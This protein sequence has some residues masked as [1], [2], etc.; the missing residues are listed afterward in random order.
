[1]T[2]ALRGDHNHVCIEEVDQMIDCDVLFCFVIYFFWSWRPVTVVHLFVHIKSDRGSC[3]KNKKRKLERELKTL[4]ISDLHTA[5]QLLCEV[6]NIVRGSVSESYRICRTQPTWFLCWKDEGE[7][8]LCT[9]RRCD[10]HFVWSIHYCL[11]SHPNINTSH[12]GGN[13]TFFMATWRL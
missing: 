11:T 10:K 12:K 7:G 5:G 1:M 6:G 4:Q 2:N 3:V 13:N 9:I 8:M